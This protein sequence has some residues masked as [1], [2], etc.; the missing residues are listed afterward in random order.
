MLEEVGARIYNYYQPD[1]SLYEHT[2][3]NARVHL[4]EAAFEEVW[5]EGWVMDFEEAVAYALD[6]KV[7]AT[8]D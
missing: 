7:D 3:G 2:A 1:R 8:G 4:G 5:A 6:R